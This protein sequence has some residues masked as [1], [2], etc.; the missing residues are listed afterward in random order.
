[1]YSATLWIVRLK[2]GTFHGSKDF[3]EVKTMAMASEHFK[4]VSETLVRVDAS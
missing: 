1:M 2:F 3:D 4:T